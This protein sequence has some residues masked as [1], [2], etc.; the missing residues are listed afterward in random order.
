VIKCVL[1]DGGGRITVEP[2]PEPVLEDGQYEI[3]VEC[4]LI[5][6]GTET[7][8]LKRRRESPTD[9]PKRPSGYSSAG[10]IRAVGEG[11]RPLAPGTRV[12]AMGGRNA[13]HKERITIGQNLVARIPDPVPTREAVM[14]CLAA[15]SLQCV[16]RAQVRIGDPVAV[17][18]QGLVGQF[19]SQLVRVNGGHAIAIDVL[20]NRLKVARDLGAD[21]VVNAKSEDPVQVVKDYT[22]GRGLKR[23]IVA[24]P[25][26][27]TGIVAQAQ[28]MMTRSENGVHQVGRVTIV[29][30][31]FIEKLRFPIGNLDICSS[32]RTGPGYHDHAWEKGDEYPLGHVEWTTRDNMAEILRLM[33]EGRFHVAPLITH[34]FPIDDAA[35]AFDTIINEPDSTLGVLLKMK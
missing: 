26:D 29:S 10:V 16:R 6:P 24:V 17:F 1:I 5:S 32:A 19:A 13:N 8:G 35:R 28:Q 14:V 7:G 11:A 27:I 15:T 20:P 22:Q 34:E 3:D 30:G 25:G 23:V 33:A 31:C 4:T 21:V 12:I 9:A 18:G 2:V